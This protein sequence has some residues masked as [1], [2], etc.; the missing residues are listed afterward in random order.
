MTPKNRSGADRRNLR[1]TAVLIPPVLAMAALFVL[2]APGALA[3]TAQIWR[4]RDRA[5]FLKGE[6]HGVAFSADGSIRL[7]PRLDLLHE[8]TRPYIWAIAPGP[9]GS[10]YAAAGNDGAI[11][12]IQADGRSEVFFQVEEPE[13]HS[14]AVDAAGNLY[15]GSAP[16][17][18]I[19]RIGPDG[20]RAWVCETGEHYVWA[21]AFDSRGRLYAATGSEGRVLAVD[22][23]GRAQTFF[24]SAETHIR[25]LA[26]DAGGDLIVGTDGHGLVFRIT[27]AGEASV[28][29]DAPL[30]EIVALALRPDGWIYAAV[31]GETGRTPPRPSMPAPSPAPSPSPTPQ[32]PEEGG[33]PAGAPPQGVERPSPVQAEQRVPIGMEGKV[34]AIAP[35]GYG[36]ELWSGTQEAIL[37]LVLD[38]GGDLLMGSSIQ[39]KIYALQRDE[40]VSEL[41]RITSGQVTALLRLDAGGSAAAGGSGGPAS[42]IAVAGSNLGTVHLLRP[43][44]AQ[45]GS[46]ESRVFDAKTFAIWG[47][48]HWRAE[49]PRRTDLGLRARC[50]NTED[51]DRTWSDWG[52]SVTDP[53]GSL[54]ACPASRF[55]QFRLEMSTKDPSLTPVV[56]EVTIA[57]LPRN[58]PPEIR[59]LEIHPP[60]VSF[61]ETAAGGAEN[62]PP[63]AEG[64]GPTRRKPKPQSRRGFE[65]GARSITWQSTDPN[66]D[67]LL[68]D[69]SYRAVDEKVWKQVRT[70][71]DEEFVTFDGTA[72]PDGTYVVRIVG[73]DAP[74]NAVDEVLT[75]EKISDQ[76]E[77]DNTPPRVE[78]ARAQVATGAIRLTF[79]AV[80]SFSLVREA[81]WSLDAGPWNPANPVD[82]L[83]D[84]AD[85]SYDLTL[86]FPGRGEHSI[87]VRATDTTGNSGSGRA[88]ITIP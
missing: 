75:V 6:P 14:L 1:S 19:Y 10:L 5:E 60:G 30:R 7:S 71:V 50:G 77:V 29:Y 68:F 61:Q 9:R 31:V 25:A 41:A 85:E 47:R 82:G 70:R 86:P 18:R 44:H 49:A 72:L 48:A 38:P 33:A 65:P 11:L 36:R 22:A 78:A 66:E 56:R 73:T 54:L 81:A 32:Q 34:L 69:I 43:G 3:V 13:V 12:K 57:Y 79:R 8:S 21:L 17:G 35:D 45:V 40:T 59:K 27:P 83:A 15:A 28:L 55:L 4:V 62:R 37:S 51:P 20:K 53:N 74:S 87:V 84:S 39:G 26:F 63:T 88:L 16:G 80:D 23:Q 58:L 42:T 52:P 64:E 24:D 2:L 67:D 46:Y 76:F